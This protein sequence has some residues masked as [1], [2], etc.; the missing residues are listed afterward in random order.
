MSTHKF[1]VGDQV[2][3]RG[4]GCIYAIQAGP[5]W[6]GPSKASYYVVREC[7]TGLLSTYLYHEDN[8]MLIKPPVFTEAH[9]SVLSA[10]LEAFTSSSFAYHFDDFLLDLQ[11]THGEKEGEE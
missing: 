7:I 6:G 10:K 11:F 9:F 5:F 3:V 1:K 2:Q 8:L 4:D